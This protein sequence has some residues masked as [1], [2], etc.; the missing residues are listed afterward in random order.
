MLVAIY[1]RVADDDGY[2]VVLV[3]EAADTK[4]NPSQVI[5]IQ[6]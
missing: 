3:E 5:N 1:D 4:M 2:L 6:N